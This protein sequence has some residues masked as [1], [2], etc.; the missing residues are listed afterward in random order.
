MLLTY[1]K[2]ARAGKPCEA[3]LDVGIAQRKV[4]AAGERLGSH[5]EIQRFRVEF[6]HRLPYA[7]DRA[8]G[9]KDPERLVEGVA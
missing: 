9:V 5:S 7:S 2:G 1:L 8:A 4:S 3:C 6:R